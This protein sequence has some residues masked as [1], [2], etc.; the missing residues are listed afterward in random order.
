ME[1][2]IPTIAFFITTIATGLFHIISCSFCI[3]KIFIYVLLHTSSSLLGIL[4]QHFL[5]TLG[6]C[7]HCLGCW[8]SFAIVEMSNYL[9]LGALVPEVIGSYCLLGNGQRPGLGF[10]DPGELK[11]NGG[12]QSQG[13]DLVT[14]YL[15]SRTALPGELK[16]SRLLTK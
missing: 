12:R 3:A 2:F 14:I 8:L 15:R 6:D 9:G 11:E 10:V 7:V 1:L 16:L 4:P 5:I 13:E